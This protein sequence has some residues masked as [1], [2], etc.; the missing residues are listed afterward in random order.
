MILKLVL[1][2]FKPKTSSENSKTYFLEWSTGEEKTNWNTV[3][4]KKNM[5]T[6]VFVHDI[7]F[8][9]SF[10]ME[11]VLFEFSQSVDH[12]ETDF[13]QI[14][15]YLTPKIQATDL[16]TLDLSQVPNILDLDFN[17]ITPQQI[18]DVTYDGKYKKARTYQIDLTNHLSF[19]QKNKNFS[20]LLEER[21][22]R[23]NG[24]DF[25]TEVMTDT[26]LRPHIRFKI[27]DNRN[28]DPNVFQGRTI[29]SHPRLL[30][31]Q[32]QIDSLKMRKDRDPD[33]SA[34]FHQAQTDADQYLNENPDYYYT[35]NLST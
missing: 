18:L 5:R 10:Q 25:L 29:A 9:Q 33:L 16:H 2:S 30:V 20:I 21:K 22:G 34:L 35:K 17:H 4:S 23:V 31:N 19:F 32:A 28:L 1:L 14:R 24:L 3:A 12:T 11:K 15:L 6:A 8:H 26:T 7:G 13:G 27:R